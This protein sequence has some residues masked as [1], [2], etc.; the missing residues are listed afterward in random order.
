MTT[1]SLALASEA[2]LQ[3]DCA[4]QAREMARAAER[5]TRPSAVFRGLQEVPAEEQGAAEALCSAAD[6][7]AAAVRE[8]LAAGEAGEA[9]RRER[10]RGVEEK[11]A[12]LRREDAERLEERKKIIV[13]NLG[14]RMKRE[15]E[16]YRRKM[17]GE[18]E[19]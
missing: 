1:R 18:E 2:L 17:L 8:A 7:A 14:E 12:E 13:R 9:A 5:A 4:E 15:E 16:E 10:W 6:E 11:M 19:G 3:N